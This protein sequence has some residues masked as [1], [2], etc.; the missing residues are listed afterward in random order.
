MSKVLAVCNYLL[1]F[2]LHLFGIRLYLFFPLDSPP[3]SLMFTPRYLHASEACCISL[4]FCSVSKA[5]S[6]QSSPMKTFHKS[7]PCS[8]YVPLTGW[9]SLSGAEIASTVCYIPCQSLLVLFR[10][11]NISC[12]AWCINISV[13][14]CRCI[15]RLTGPN[16]ELSDILCPNAISSHLLYT[17]V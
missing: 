8:S 11:I 12:C 6:F 5:R 13:P 3:A 17:L 15:V 10:C 4:C 16:W 2:R 7:L 9:D 14:Y 1:I